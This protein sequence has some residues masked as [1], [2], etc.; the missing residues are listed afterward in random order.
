MSIDW[1]NDYPNSWKIII[2]GCVCQG[3]FQKW[4]TCDP[5]DQIKKICSQQY[6][7]ESSNILR[8]D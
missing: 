4:L 6:G 7:W 8:P 5:V 2:S 3:C 1:A